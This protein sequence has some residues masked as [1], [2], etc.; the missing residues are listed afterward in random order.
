MSRSSYQSNGKPLSQQALYQQK[1]R[2]GIYTS[3]SVASIGVNSNASDTA[4]LLAASADLTVKPV[5]ERVV[6]SDAQY[7]A[8]A[9][10]T[11][12][13]PAW[14]RV[15]DSNADAAAASARTSS[16]NTQSSSTYSAGGTGV[17]SFNGNTIYKAASQNSA[18]T[19]TSRSNPEKD[20]MRSGLAIKSQSSTMDIGKISQM[21]NKNSAKS[22]NSRFN[23]ELDYRSGLKINNS[24]QFLNQKEEDLAASGAAASLKHGSG[25]SDRASA[26]RRSQSFKAVDVVDGNLL[27]AASAKA[28]ERLNSLN[29]STLKDFKSQ[30]QA[31]AKALTV[32]QQNSDERLKNHQIGRIDLGGG[33]FMTQAELDN[34]ASLIVRPILTD[35]DKKVAVQRESDD[36][37]KTEQANLAVLHQNAKQAEILQKSQEKADFELAKEKRGQENEEKKSNEDGLFVQH[38]EE[39]NGEV[40]TKVTELGELQAKYA[41]EKEALLTEKQENS[42][43]IDE[44]EAELIDGRKKELEEMQAERDEILQPTLDELK[45]ENA[46]LKDVTDARDELKNE[47]TAAEKVNEDYEAQVAELTAKLEETKAEIEKFTTDIEEADTKLVETTNVVDELHKTS[48]AELED[49]EK[50]DKELD[51]KL[52]ELDE[53]KSA[54]L[55]TKSSNKDE[56]KNLIDE[57]VKGEHKINAELPEH[58][59]KDVNE[60]KLRDTAS[61]FTVETPKV[62]EVPLFEEPK[63]AKV[64]KSVKAE[65]KPEATTPKRRNGLRRLSNIFKSSK[66]KTTKA[67]PVSSKTTKA[68]VSEPSKTVEDPPKPET[69][70]KKEEAKPKPTRTNTNTNS[71]TEY[72]DDLSLNNQSKNQGGL[73]K[74]EI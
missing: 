57:S 38:Q 73:F 26:Q 62:K 48:A 33:L 12:E 34:M 40:E 53:Q 10:K 41:Q 54:H 2:Q 65:P 52:K 68:A 71:T 72:D 23:P 7:A 14:K 55:A 19:M 1:L 29:S 61:L 5:Y 39:R 22:L 28:Q 35:I 36:A 31:Y 15:R 74:E 17:P 42:D 8:L 20:V 9:A 51:S 70:A 11:E 66:D 64:E 4:A 3:P 50:T 45:E 18:S 16:M 49:A 6:A 13:I 25:Y 44:E 46:K 27:A 60:D 30:A 47:V 43:R 37:Y 58:F 67:A 32:A 63:V 24:T 69:I 56:I 59:R 21:A